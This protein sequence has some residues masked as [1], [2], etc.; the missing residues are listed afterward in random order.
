MSSHSVN[1]TNI[2]KTQ[3]KIDQISSLI[4]TINGELSDL[5]EELTSEVTNINTLLKCKAILAMS[6][7]L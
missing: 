2:D 1:L 3:T 5:N 4:N 6:I 7:I